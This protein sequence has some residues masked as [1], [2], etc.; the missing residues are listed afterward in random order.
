MSLVVSAAQPSHDVAGMVMTA[1]QGPDFQIPE[2]L[3][4]YQLPA[5]TYNNN[6]TS[7]STSGLE[8]FVNHFQ[9][10]VRVIVKHEGTVPI[11]E[12]DHFEP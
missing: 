12:M 6:L 9:L 8:T 5:K 3:I 1:C 2:F 11:Q 4:T 7:S 10:S